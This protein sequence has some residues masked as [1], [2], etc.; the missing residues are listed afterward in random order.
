MNKTVTIHAIAATL[1][2]SLVMV[3][4]IATV[5]TEVF[6]S[7]T[8]IV[9][10]K[11]VIVRYGLVFMVFTMMVT[12]GSGMFLA[13]QRNK[14]SDS[15]KKQRMPWIALNGVFCLLPSAIYLSFKASAGEF[16]VWFAS[17]QVLE[18]A[19]GLMQMTLLG[20]NFA[21]GIRLVNR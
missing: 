8:E 12:G 13:R 3:F 6:L 1:A 19:M 5:V 2:L 11:A 17:V 16:D 21:A 15:L 20:R 14:P 7:T 9:W 10:V 18:L 4:W